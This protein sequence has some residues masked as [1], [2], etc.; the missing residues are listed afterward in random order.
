[1]ETKC[2][3]NGGVFTLPAFFYY[4]NSRNISEVKEAFLDHR[5]L[6]PSFS[7]ISHGWGV[8]RDK[9]DEMTQGRRRRNGKKEVKGKEKGSGANASIILT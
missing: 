1:M 4:G 7:W 3:H 8:R 5:P 2:P 9:T 6:P